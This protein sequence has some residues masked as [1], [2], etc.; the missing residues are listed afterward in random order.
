MTGGNSIDINELNRLVDEQPKQTWAKPKHN[1]FITKYQLHDYCL[2][3]SCY[4]ILTA[5]EQLHIVDQLTD[6][7]SSYNMEHNYGGGFLE[8]AMLEHWESA[9]RNADP[10]NQNCIEI[11][12]DFIA[13]KLP[14]DHKAVF[15]KFLLDW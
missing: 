9:F 8:R 2:K 14:E 6:I 5:E 15:R 4:A 7:I 12:K 13:H 10:T 1:V 3:W 11:Y